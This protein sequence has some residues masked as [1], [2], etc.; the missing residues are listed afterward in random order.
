MPQFRLHGVEVFYR[1]EGAGPPI[2]LGHS[3]A[4]SSGQWR[5]MIDRLSERYRLLAP[6]QLGCG[7]TGVYPGTPAL[8][9]FETAIFEALLD[10]ADAPAHLVGHSYGGMIMA[11]TAVR[12]PD[13]VRS[14]SLIEPALFHLLLPAGRND[15]HAEI[16]A[17]ADRVIRYIDAGDPEKAA[18]TFIDYWVT[19]GA[20]DSMDARTRS[21]VVAS[22]PKL[23]MEWS[24]VF[25]PWSA[26]ATALGKLRLR[27]QLIRAKKTTRAGHAV[28]DV[29]RE[30]WPH[31]EMQE[32]EGA[33]H[34]SPLTHA[35]RVCAILEE[36]LHRQIQTPLR[37]PQILG[38][39]SP[40][41]REDALGEL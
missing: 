11:R 13:R 16:K 18:R 26:T 2:I 36:F 24:E 35:D 3:S 5:S 14:L 12:N 34:M 9:D 29:L 23:R 31:S 15:A 32:I 20:Y 39:N 40:S 8:S 17:I 22:T 30:I 37:N 21:A 19:M 7:R 28:T 25:K 1:D 41:T 38:A 10:L 4:G 6:D 33:G 27:V